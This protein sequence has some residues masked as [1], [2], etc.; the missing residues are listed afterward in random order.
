MKLRPKKLASQLSERKRKKLTQFVRLLAIGCD[1]EEVIEQM[2]L[3][4]S[5][6][7]ELLENFYKE[8]ERDFKGKSS[9]RIFTDYTTRQVQFVKDLED[10]KIALQ[11]MNWKNGQAYVAAVK[12]QSDIFDKIITTGQ[13]LGVIVKTPDQVLFVGGRDARDMESDELDVAIKKELE[14]AKRIAS[15]SRDEKL[16]KAAN[17]IALYPKPREDD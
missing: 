11:K 12:T 8:A 2:G 15:S 7:E 5:E 1:R 9:L 13:N 14:E 3:N 6:Y 16:K 10:L 4:N 17:V